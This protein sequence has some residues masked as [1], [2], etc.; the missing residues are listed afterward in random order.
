MLRYVLRRFVLVVPTLIGILTLVFILLK[1]IPGDPAIAL[2]GDKAT[3]EQARWIREEIRTGS[4]FADPVRLFHKVGVDT[5]FWAVVADPSTGSARSCGSF[6]GRRIEFSLAALLI[7]LVVGIPLGVIAA[8]RRN[9]SVDYGSMIFALIGISMPVYWSGI[10]AFICSSFRLGL[11]PI[12]GIMDSQ[13]SLHH[14]T[15]GYVT[16]SVLTGNWPAFRSSLHHLLLP[17]I[18]LST[19][20]MA[21]IARMAR[22]SMLEVLGA[23]LSA[24]RPRQGSGRA[25]R[26]RQACAQKR[27]HPGG[28]R[29]R[30][31]IRR[32]ALRRV[33]DR[34]GLRATRHRP[35]CRHRDW[36]SRLPGHSGDRLDRGR[37]LRHD[38]SLCRSH[39][40]LPRSA[41]PLRI[42]ETPWRWTTS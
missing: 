5:R 13:I 7:A 25:H 3:A 26:H 10:V 31:A 23:G 29:H 40:R 4:S 34:D 16:D 27:A 12:A 30:S 9:T 24:N 11:F 2:A 22:S 38:Q 18:V 42:T 39:L 35:L 36:R 33:L 14:I 20:P 41:N 17:A 15:Y 6:S 21:I 32:S 1:A 28:D 8:T 37:A 19:I